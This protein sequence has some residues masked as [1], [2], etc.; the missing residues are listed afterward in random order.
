[1]KKK[2]YYAEEKSQSM[3]ERYWQQGKTGETMLKLSSVSIDDLI[4][5]I[6]PEVIMYYFH[7][8]MKH[9]YSEWKKTIFVCIKFGLIIEIC[10]K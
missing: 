10:F 1:M 5:N 8:M 4:E 7:T 6:E 2:T 3:N 9:K